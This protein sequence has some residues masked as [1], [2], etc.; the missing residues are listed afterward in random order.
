MVEE[1]VDLAPTIVTQP[2]PGQLTGTKTESGQI[3]RSLRRTATPR[4]GVSRLDA[5]APQIGAP[6]V[7]ARS[8]R[9]WWLWATGG[10]A[11]AAVTGAAVIVGQW[12]T[13]VG[14]PVNRPELT[15]AAPLGVMMAATVVSEPPGAQISIDDN[16]TRA[17]TPATVPLTGSFPKQLRLALPGYQTLEVSLAGDGAVVSQYDYALERLQGSAIL[18]LSGAY[19]FEVL[20]D[21]RVVSGAAA[22]HRLEVPVGPT[23]L[24]LRNREYFLNRR[25]D[26]T[27]EANDQRRIPVPGLGDLAVFAAV[28]TCRV[29]IAGRDVG[30]PPVP[31]QPIVAGTYRVTLRCPDGTEESNRVTVRAGE[32]AVVTFGR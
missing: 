3:D 23:T 26:V 14:P 2:K 21:G 19:P 6:D 15:I 20:Q 12:L 7:A 8:G 18:T 13:A 4:S 11:V 31:R 16:D 17:V 32:R 29:V 5:R 10:V 25:V 30:F 27:T 28:E 1:S 9:R 22:Q 24:Q